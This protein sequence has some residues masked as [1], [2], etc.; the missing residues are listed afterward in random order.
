MRHMNWRIALMGFILIVLS[1]AF[2]FLMLSLAPSS[3]DPV[4]MMVTVGTVFGPAI[5]VSV[6]LILI[7]LIGENI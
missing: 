1:L 7:G 4:T 2:Y 3:T 5:G 6:L